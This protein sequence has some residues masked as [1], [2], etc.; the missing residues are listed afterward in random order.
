[1]EHL[2]LKEQYITTAKELKEELNSYLEAVKSKK[3]VKLLSSHSEEFYGQ[4][5]KLVSDFCHMVENTELLNDLEPMWYYNCEIDDTG[6][7]LHLCHVGRL[8]VDENDIIDCISIDEDFELV[9]VNARLLTV[10]EYAKIYGVTVGTVRQWIRRGK[11]RTAIKAGSEW[12]IPELTELHGRGYTEGRYF[13]EENLDN[14]P[15]EYSFLVSCCH[16]VIKQAG[17]DTFNVICDYRDSEEER[18]IKMSTKEREKFELF[19]ITKDGTRAY[20][21]R[22]EEIFL[23]NAIYN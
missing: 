22:F 3:I 2:I 4:Y 19:L 13:C 12:R 1:M 23:P 10:E 16:V 21:E 11:I 5:L 18:C 15:E 9:K 8:E 6:A 7:S 14:I 17:C 20:E